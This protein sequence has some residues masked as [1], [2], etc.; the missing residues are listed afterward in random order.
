[1][2][3]SAYWR[4]SIATR[5]HLQVH[6][7]E[8]EAVLFDGGMSKMLLCS[9]SDLVAIAFTMLEAATLHLFKP[10]ID[11]LLNCIQTTHS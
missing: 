5:L 2:S 4:W 8:V 11:C 9:L 1:M 10:T 7:M 6:S 3:S